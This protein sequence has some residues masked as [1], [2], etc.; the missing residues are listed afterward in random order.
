MRQNIVQVLGV[1]QDSAATAHPTHVVTEYLPVSLYD[2]LHRDRL[3]LSRREIALIAADVLRALLFLHAKGESFG[4]TL[5]SRKVMLGGNCAAKL[6]RFNVELVQRTA[7]AQPERGSGMS[8]THSF[9]K[10]QYDPEAV[11]ESGDRV[12]AGLPVARAD[13]SASSRDGVDHD[14]ARELPEHVSTAQK[15]DLYAFGILLLEMITSEKPSTETYNRISCADQ[16]DPVFG[17]LVRF[18]LSCG[19]H[20]DITEMGRNEPL[21]S[22]LGESSAIH[23]L[24]LLTESEHKRQE[25]HDNE[26]PPS[27]CFPCFLYADRFAVAAEQQRAEKAVAVRESQSNVALKRLGAVEQELLDE[28]SNFAVLVQQFEKA[29]LEKQHLASEACEMEA[30]LQRMQLASVDAN[31]AIQRLSGVVH[32]QREEVEWLHM[33]I[34]D[35]HSCVGRQQDSK[36]ADMTE[37]QSLMM[38]ILKL[39]NEKRRL[40]DEKADCER[41]ASRL[42]AQVGGE[43]DA[44]E[45]IEGRWRQATFKAEQEQKGRRKLERQNEQLSAQLLRMEEER[46]VYSFALSQCP[47]GLLDPKRATAYIIELK[48]Q[49]IQKLRESAEQR[50]QTV[51]ELRQAIRDH[52]HVNKQLQEAQSRLRE[53]NGEV[54]ARNA[55]LASDLESKHTEIARLVEKLQLSA[56]RACE[57]S[58]RVADLEEELERQTKKRADEGSF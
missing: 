40:T 2:A 16:M 47:T 50:E 42:A 58:A 31:A 8:E 14:D 55:A 29:E 48:E 15:R 36:R 3:I 41:S 6:R 32:S 35:Y 5:T 26:R 24:E 19:G 56:T 20:P 53:V 38:D 43:K 22:G 49:E 57:L 13:L 30:K 51:S 45:D 54:E 34:E 7:T 37:K 39:T 1:A 9:W 28:Q 12:C 46:S 21:I 17:Q 33:I 23:F 4:S 18:A 11:R 10:T 44:M 25:Q 52:H 27:L